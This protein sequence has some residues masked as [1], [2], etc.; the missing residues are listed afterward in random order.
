MKFDQLI[1]HNKKMFFFKNYAGD[2]ARRLVPDCSYF[3]K[4][5]NM[6]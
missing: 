5:L 2:E 3:F 6:R 4:K 1:E